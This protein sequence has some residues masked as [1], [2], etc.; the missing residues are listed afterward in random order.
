M[1]FISLP[2]KQWLPIELVGLH[3]VCT[4]SHLGAFKTL[5]AWLHSDQWH[6]HADAQPSGLFKAPRKDPRL[7]TRLRTADLIILKGLCFSIISCFYQA[8]IQSCDFSSFNVF[9]KLGRNSC[10]VLLSPL[11][12]C[13]LFLFTYDG[14]QPTDLQLWFPYN[15]Y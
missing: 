2:V 14:T 15:C 12:I 11:S 9:T 4:L 1:T 5:H 6:Q 8:P 13:C 3:P 10:D 7:W